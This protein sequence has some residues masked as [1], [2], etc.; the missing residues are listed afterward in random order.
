ML[1]GPPRPAAG[2][3]DEATLVQPPHRA[4]PKEATFEWCI[5]WDIL[6]PHLDPHGL[7]IARDSHRDGDGDGGGGGVGV[8]RVTAMVPGAGTSELSAQ[9]H[10]SGYYDL[11]TS[12]DFDAGCTQHMAARH[13]GT[14]ALVWATADVCDPV[15]VATVVPPGSCE[16]VIDKATL[17]Y[18]L[19]DATQGSHGVAGYLQAMHQS[20]VPGGVVAVVSF[21]P[22]EFLMPIFAGDWLVC[23]RWE[24][25]RIES[26]PNMP[27]I[28]LLVARRPIDGPPP[29]PIADLAAHVSD[30]VAKWHCEV[31]PLLTEAERTRILAA[32]P[33][34]PE[35]APTTADLRT[36]HA[37]LFAEDLRLEFPLPDFQDGLID[38]GAITADDLDPRLS[39]D[40]ALQF[41][42]ANQ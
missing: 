15:A 7:G 38:E 3:P 39:L 14:D 24:R 30:A 12:V 5:G 9:L 17:D 31:D 25:I 10:S 42:G 18:V 35:G 29:P 21:H 11:V 6:G 41:L 34:D 32:W 28:T 1:S 23:E 33:L 20:V 13:A 4:S 37:I 16:L 2:A 40:A 8:G 26:Q 27:T 36:A 19:A 22:P